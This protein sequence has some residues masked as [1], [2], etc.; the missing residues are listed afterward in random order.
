M[1]LFLTSSFQSSLKTTIT[2]W[3]FVFVTL[4]NLQGTRCVLQRFLMISLRFPF[5]KNFFQKFFN[6]FSSPLI[7]QALEVLSPS[8]SQATYL[9]YHTQFALSR[10]F[11][12]F[13]NCFVL[14]SATVFGFLTGF[15]LGTGPLLKA[16][17]YIIRT[18][19]VCQL[20]FTG[21]F[22]FFTFLQ[23]RPNVP[24]ILPLHAFVFPL[25]STHPCALLS[26]SPAK[27]A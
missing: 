14:A 6:L 21:F 3:C 8:L 20:F 22:L 13:S 23:N 27:W 16:L 1:T 19:P 24:L 10:T 12:S 15:C 2:F 4:F 11:S 5:V 26:M 9:G 18:S 25:Y 17:A 7:R